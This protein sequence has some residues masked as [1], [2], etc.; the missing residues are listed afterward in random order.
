VAGCCVLLVCK[1]V[2]PIGFY[3]VCIS[4]G[5]HRII[6]I[7]KY[8]MLVYCLVIGSISL[9]RAIANSTSSVLSKFARFAICKMCLLTP[10]K[11]FLLLPF[12]SKCKRSVCI[13]AICFK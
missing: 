2:S 12:P 9:Y 3:R 6:L 13:L 4:V 5:K 1:L 10:S 11:V 7:C 8:L